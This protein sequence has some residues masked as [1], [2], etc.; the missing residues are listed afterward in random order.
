MQVDGTMTALLFF[1][2]FIIIA[3]YLLDIFKF[4]EYQ[5]LVYLLQKA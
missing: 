1:V 4:H 2:K 5:V 3:F